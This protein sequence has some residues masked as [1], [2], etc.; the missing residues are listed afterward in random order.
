MGTAGHRKMQYQYQ[1]VKGRAL[2]HLGAQRHGA[3]DIQT[4]ERNNLIIWSGCL[5]PACLAC[6]LTCSNFSSQTPMHSNLQL[7]G[8]WI[9]HWQSMLTADDLLHAVSD[10]PLHADHN[11]IFRSSPEYRRRLFEKEDG[12]PDAQ[13]L[14]YTHDRDYGAFKYGTPIL[15]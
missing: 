12:P 3:D 15:V 1:H 4:G 7:I 9:C 14:S 6:I 13:C 10:L 5:L 2:V 11:D 8:K